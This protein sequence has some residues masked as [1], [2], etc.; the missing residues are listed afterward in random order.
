MSEEFENSP[1]D[2]PT[3]GSTEPDLLNQEQPEDDLLASTEQQETSPVDNLLD[4][5]VSNNNFS[6]E[7]IAGFNNDSIKGDGSALAAWKEKRAEEIR[8]RDSKDAKAKAE[9]QEAAVKHID[10]FYEAYNNKKEQQLEQVRKD[11]EQFAKDRENFSNQ[12]GTTTWDR[13][14]QLINIEDADVVGGRDRSKFKEIL[15]KLK[16]NPNAP[17]A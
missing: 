9:L 8:E 13:A 11:A 4:T 10:E 6:S 5:S 7:N 3:V 16:G 12:V 15:L 14:L 17:G 1:F 2:D